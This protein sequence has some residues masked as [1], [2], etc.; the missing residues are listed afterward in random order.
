MADEL[1]IL[2]RFITDK[3]AKEG[4]V[5]AIDALQRQMEDFEQSIEEAK[6][7]SQELKSLSKEI[8]QASREAFLIGTAIT[9]GIFAAANKYVKDAKEATAVT[10]AWKAAQEGLNRSGTRI[11]ASL[12]QEALPLLERAAVIS[13]KVAG[14][15]ES[16]PEIVRA[17]LNTGLV[18]ASLGA[19]GI[20]VSK[21][22][23]IYADVAYLAAVA[24]EAQGFILFDNA[25]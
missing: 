7:S 23:R 9:G 12:A 14:F 15:V 17:A 4:T 18:V 20:A 24:K 11:G 8:A 25:E 16:H 10:V 5:A 1:D 21:G 19:V 3:A 6:K 22:I 2:I 13:D